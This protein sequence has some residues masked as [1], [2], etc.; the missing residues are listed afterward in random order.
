MVTAKALATRGLSYEVRDSQ[1]GQPTE[2]R[3][4]LFAPVVEPNAFYQCAGDVPQNKNGASPTGDA[5][6]YA[7]A[8]LLLF[9]ATT[10]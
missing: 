3:A 2:S 9:A 8:L 7:K 1:A 4:F 6:M 5:P 10:V